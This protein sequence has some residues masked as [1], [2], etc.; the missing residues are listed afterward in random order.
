MEDFLIAPCV[1]FCDVAMRKP[2][3][4]Q[5]FDPDSVTRL[6]AKENKNL[7]K[8]VGYLED[9]ASCFI[10]SK[11]KSSIMLK[12]N[13]VAALALTNF[14]AVYDLAT[15]EKEVNWKICFDEL[16]RDCVHSYDILFELK[17]LFPEPMI[18]STTKEP[19]AYSSDLTVIVI[20]STENSV[21][22]IELQFASEGEIKKGQKMSISRNPWSKDYEYV[23]IALISIPYYKICN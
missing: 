20:Y 7:D 10:L 9:L 21:K 14:H 15:Y 19:Y 13:P 22:L 18:S 12:N 3:L 5:H 4:S 23:W 1:G 16:R 11:S 8:F 6:L 2:F 17:S